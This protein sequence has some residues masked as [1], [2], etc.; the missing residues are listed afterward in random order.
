MPSEEGLF[1]GDDVSDD[2]TRAQRENNVLVVWVQ[3]EALLDV[4]FV[5][6]DCFD[7]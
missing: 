6:D 5:S 3:D 4:A 2:Y 7:F 1:P